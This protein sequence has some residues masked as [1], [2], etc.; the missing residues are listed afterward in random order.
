MIFFFCAVVIAAMV[1]GVVYQIVSGKVLDRSW[2][3]WATR[4]EQPG[5]YWFGV[6]FQSIIVLIPIVMLIYDYFGH[7]R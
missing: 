2:K 6:A 3:V 5:R 7:K 4:A 1:G